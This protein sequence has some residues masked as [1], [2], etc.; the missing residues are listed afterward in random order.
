MK[1][2]RLSA[3]AAV[4][5]ATGIVAHASGPIAVYAKIDRVVMEPNEQAPERVQVFGVFSLGSATNT[6][7][8]SAPARGYL[9]YSLPTT[10]VAPSTPELNRRTALNEWKD[11]KAVAGDN[12][13]YAFG[14]QW[15][16]IPTLHKT[17][18]T[19][20]SPDEFTLN[21]GIRKINA[22]NATFAPIKA[23]RDFK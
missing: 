23:L 4:A 9:Y 8:F 18:E 10:G 13:I 19:P 1:V 17:G 7:S 6:N 14:A 16:G 21:V 22:A 3:A 20:S 2:L 15:K 5:L 11:L 12:E